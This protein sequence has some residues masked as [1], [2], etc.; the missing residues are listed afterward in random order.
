MLKALKE[1][2]AGGAN[3]LQGRT[4][5]LEAV[6]AAAALVAI[7]DGEIED[8]E[9]EATVK[10]VKANEA[11]NTAFDSRQIEGAIQRMLDRAQ[12]GRVGQ[13]GLYKEI[14]DVAGS[15]EDAELVYLTALDIAEADG[16]VEPQEQTVLAK[17]AKELGINQA[18][19]A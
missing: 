12:G 1:R 14:R 16:E 17:I 4:D 8:S 5:I 11:L 9:V 15:T 7:A 10:A 18:S 6:T 13:M 19:Y 3:R 2:L